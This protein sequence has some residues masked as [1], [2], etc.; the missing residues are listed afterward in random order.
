MGINFRSS[1]LLERIP[2]ALKFC[3]KF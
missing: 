2:K 1:D 3:E